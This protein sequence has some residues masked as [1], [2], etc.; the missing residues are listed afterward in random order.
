MT[1]ARATNYGTRIDYIFGDRDLVTRA[2]T[3]CDIMQ[4]VEGSDHCPVKATLKWEVTPTSKC[5]SLCT[6]YMPEFLGTQKKLSSFFTKVSKK[7]NDQLPS[8]QESEDSGICTAFKGANREVDLNM[9]QTTSKT[10]DIGCLNPGVNSSEQNA[11]QLFESQQSL[12]RTKSDSNHNSKRLKTSDK[13]PSIGKQGSLLKFFGKSA[14]SSTKNTPVNSIGGGGSSSN[15]KLMG[16]TSDK[17]L[18]DL[19]ERKDDAV[20]REKD[21]NDSKNGTDKKEVV[22]SWKQL[23]KGPP[24]APLCKGHSEPCLLRTVKKEDSLNKGRQFWVC[25]RPEGHKTNV[26]ARCDTFIWVDKKKK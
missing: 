6:K 2:F 10:T 11:S 7:V 19:N 15:T 24:T 20:V 22:S 26:E 23:L 21:K 5:P 17:S 8:S 9:F 1:G 13:K 3:D 25:N 14:V 18:L 12:K 16:D 4:E